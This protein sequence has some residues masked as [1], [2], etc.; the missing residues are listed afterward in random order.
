MSVGIDRRGFDRIAGIGDGPAVAQ[1]EDRFEDADTRL[2]AGRGSA[3]V[4]FNGDRDATVLIMRLG[5]AAG[6]GE[7]HNSV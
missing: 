3:V 4:L 6:A 1:V 7:G 2:D 5:V